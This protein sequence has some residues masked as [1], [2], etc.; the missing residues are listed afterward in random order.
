MLLTILHIIN[1]LV[2]TA[3]LVLSPYVVRLSAKAALDGEDV[4]KI[5]I[6]TTIMVLAVIAYVLLTAITA[7]FIFN[8]FHA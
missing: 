7:N 6:Y 2:M 5:A 8:A 3:I 4:P 1:L